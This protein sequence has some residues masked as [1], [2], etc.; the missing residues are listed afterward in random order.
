[1]T[2]IL[3][4]QCSLDLK[5][6]VIM[7]L[8]H[9]VQKMIILLLASPCVADECPQYDVNLAQIEAALSCEVRVDNCSC[10]N[11]A[12]DTIAVLGS[13]EHF[14]LGLIGLI[15]I[16]EAAV[17][18][19]PLDVVANHLDEKVL[20]LGVSASNAPSVCLSEDVFSNT[21]EEKQIS[22]SFQHLYF[23]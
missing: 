2:V 19:V 13:A 11:K 10:E 15:V 3:I 7:H 6:E 23:L 21:T 14:K 5:R 4:L 12:T 16:I 9:H 20:V 17:L 22:R 18:F 1:M 8:Q